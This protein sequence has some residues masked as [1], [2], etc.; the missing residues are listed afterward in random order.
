MSSV[1]QTLLDST[2]AECAKAKEDGITVPE[3]IKIATTVFQGIYSLK[4]VSLAEKKA[5]V[6]MALQRGLNAAG[7]LQGLSHVDPAIVA[8][9]E[10]QVLHMAM[11]AV[12]GLADAFPQVFAGVETG[13]SYI[14]SSLSK[15]LPGYSGASQAV[16][17]VLGPKDAELIAEAVKNLTA[18]LAPPA[19]PAAP[20]APAPAPALAVRTVETTQVSVAPELPL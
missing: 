15:C 6:F 5:F 14:M 20:A 4:A 8:E 1:L 13:L 19:A 18:A 11:A 7:R 3:V 10:K 16:A 12:F 9:V 17:V 2:I